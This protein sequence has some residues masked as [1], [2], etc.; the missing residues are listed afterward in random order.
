MADATDTTPDEAK[1]PVTDL[2]DEATNPDPEALPLPDYAADAI[3]DARDTARALAAAVRAA[4][5]RGAAVD[6]TEVDRQTARL[7]AHSTYA[8]VELLASGALTPPVAT[9]E[10][11]NTFEMSTADVAPTPE[12]EAAPTAEGENP[13]AKPENPD[14]AP[15][16][17]AGRTS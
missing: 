8:L 4:A 14:A 5:T 10:T 16:K 2:T 15:A 6:K 9:I 11:F 13:D 1:V 7:H 17:K 3:E 12:P